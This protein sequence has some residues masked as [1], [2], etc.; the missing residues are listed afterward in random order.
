MNFK[1]VIK[2]FA[3]Y[4]ALCVLLPNVYA[5]EPS[6]VIKLTPEHQFYI[7]RNGGI[8]HNTRVL[9]KGNNKSFFKESKPKL[10]DMDEAIRA[11]RE[12][13]KDKYINEQE[14]M[15][16]SLSNPENLSKFIHMKTYGDGKAAKWLNSE[17]RSDTSDFGLTEPLST[18]FKQNVLPDFLHYAFSEF[19]QHRA[20][21]DKAIGELQ[22]NQQ[23]AALATMEI[24]K[25]LNLSYLVVKTEYAT[26]ETLDSGE[27]F[28]IIMEC[29]KGIPFKKIKKLGYGYKDIAPSFQKDISNL[30]ILDALCA[31]R[32]R[33]VGNFFTVISETSEKKSIVGVSGYDNELAFTDYKALKE[34]HFCLPALINSD[35]TLVLPHMDKTLAYNILKV[36]DNDIRLCLKDL[37][38]EVNINATLNRLCQIKNAIEISKNKNPHFLIEAS[39]WNEKTIADEL[40]SDH[41][42][43]LKQYVKKLN[44]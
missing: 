2:L 38:N 35:D 39:E 34:Q 41:D 13:F 4:I 17:D 44:K 33:S 43:Y 16:K 6:R 19:V 20:N 14:L 12:Y 29:A 40:T 26:I 30:M 5:I 8:S 42:T 9:E 11:I 22:I 32:D 28:G 23:L 36:S 7:H 25:L 1:K 24:A 31:Q 21:Q 15:I 37:L 27:K 18:D 10:S 3:L